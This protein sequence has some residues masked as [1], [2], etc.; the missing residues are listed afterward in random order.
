MSDASVATS[1]R[2]SA[3]SPRKASA[4]YI[5]VALFVL[6]SLWVPDTFLTA[7]TWRSLLASQAITALVAIALV[8]PL[9]A[10]VFNLAIGAEVGMGGIL[11]AWL[12]GTQGVPVGAAIALTLLGGAVIGL[13]SGLL[14]VRARIDSFIATLGV[15]SVL[16]ALSQWLSGGQQILELGQGFQDIATSQLFGV[17]LPVYF[18]LVISAVVYYIIELTPSGRNLYATGGNLPAAALS[19]VKTARV[20]VIATVSCGILAAFAGLLQSAQV[21][22]GD[23]TAGPGYLLPAFAAAFLGSTQFKPG[24][25]N[26]PGTLVAVVVLATGVKGLQLAGAPVWIPDLFNGVALLLAVGVALRERRG[27]AQTSAI[28]RLLRR[29]DQPL[30]VDAAAA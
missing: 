21:A 25:Y 2:L 20:I 30:A 18:V 15:S 17:V 12:L 24:R 26:V 9:A 29:R 7:G 5:F 13:A 6:F 28:R 23:P 14:I 4:I 3:L 1:R 16:I 19:G 10:G 8:I 27:A 11:V 22:T